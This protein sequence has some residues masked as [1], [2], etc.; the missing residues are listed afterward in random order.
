MTANQAAAMIAS[1][2]NY[3]DKAPSTFFGKNGSRSRPNPAFQPSP[4]RT[5]PSSSSPRPVDPHLVPRGPLGSSPSQRRTA[6]TQRVDYHVMKRDTVATSVSHGSRHQSPA[7]P[8]RQA[9]P[10]VPSGVF[11][12]S[13]AAQ[14]GV[15][16]DPSPSA[17][18]GYPPSPASTV[19]SRIVGASPQ[20]PRR[21]YQARLTSLPVEAEVESVLSDPPVVAIAPMISGVGACVGELPDSL[22]PG[23]TKG[24]TAF[25]IPSSAY[26]RNAD[27]ALKRPFESMPAS[28]CEDDGSDAKRLKRA[29]LEHDWTDTSRLWT[30]PQWIPP[31]PPPAVTRLRST[32][33]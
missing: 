3:M 12:P 23:A 9:L 17:L 14:P 33:E 27:K 32:L 5:L 28:G 15:S 26:I 4:P 8:S 1:Q 18:L 10:S 2:D 13:P 29:G 16:D 30:L 20:L 7:T 22:V 31:S 19:D 24:R 11:P 25:A 6:S 21:C